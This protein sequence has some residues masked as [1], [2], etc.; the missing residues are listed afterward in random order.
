M[1]SDV[2]VRLFKLVMNGNSGGGDIKIKKWVYGFGI[3]SAKLNRRVK[4]PWCFCI[5]KQQQPNISVT[6]NEY[7]GTLCKVNIPSA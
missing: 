4:Q 2:G 3:K 1:I 6:S 5:T 7:R